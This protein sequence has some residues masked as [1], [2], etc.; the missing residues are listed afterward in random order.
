MPILKR[1]NKEQFLTEVLEPV[2]SHCCREMVDVIRTRPA[3]HSADCP[4]SQARRPAQGLHAVV[5]SQ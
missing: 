1:G 5:S 2:A 3:S 4:Q